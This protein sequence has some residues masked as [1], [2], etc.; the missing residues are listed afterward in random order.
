MP[1]VL[2]HAMHVHEGH[3]LRICGW[4]TLQ[5]AAQHLQGLLRMQ[6][7]LPPI[8]DRH[9]LEDAIMGA[10]PD[11]F[12]TP[13]VHTTFLKGTVILLPFGIKPHKWM[14]FLALIPQL[15]AVSRCARDTW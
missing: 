8:P 12:A 15:F 1:V 5:A 2:L 7:Q 10:L 14:R 3:W 9:A 6:S 11:L 13:K 4:S